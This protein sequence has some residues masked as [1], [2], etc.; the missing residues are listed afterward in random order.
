MDRWDA[1][2]N[3]WNQWV[4]GYNP[5][6]QRNFLSRVGFDDATWHTMAIAMLGTTALVLVGLTGLSALQPARAG[7]RSG[8]AGV[9][10]I[11]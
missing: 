8:A 7:Q 1:L 10:E 3:A 4:L 5:E 6:R 11:L 9:E 2:A